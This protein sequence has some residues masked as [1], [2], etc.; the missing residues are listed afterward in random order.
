MRENFNI[1]L[2]TQE[3]R[4][5]DNIEDSENA[6]K[7]YKEYHVELRDVPIKYGANE[8]A[9]YTKKYVPVSLSTEKYI[10]L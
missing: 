5:F 8:L 1:M 10:Y 6:S 9:N 3:L 4:Q 7:D 2:E